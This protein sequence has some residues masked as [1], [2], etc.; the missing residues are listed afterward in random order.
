MALLSFRDVVP[1]NDNGSDII[2]E[3]R[4]KHIREDAHSGWVWDL[5]PDDVDNTST[6]YSASWDNSVRV[7]DLETFDCIEKFWYVKFIF[8]YSYS[9]HSYCSFTF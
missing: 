1:Q 9:I 6:I 3:A 4:P 8:R 5:A 2:A 7:W